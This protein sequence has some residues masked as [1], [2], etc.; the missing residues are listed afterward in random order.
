MMIIL[1]TAA[2]QETTPNPLLYLMADAEKGGV[3]EKQGAFRY[4]V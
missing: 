3:E 4:W 1:Q 2:L